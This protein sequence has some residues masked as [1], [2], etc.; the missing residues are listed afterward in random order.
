MK[1]DLSLDIYEQ[2]Y[3]LLDHRSTHDCLPELENCLL[4][5]RNPAKDRAY[6]FD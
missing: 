2:F 4:M 3:E 5:S 1:F 6:S